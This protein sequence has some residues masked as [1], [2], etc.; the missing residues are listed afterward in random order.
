M[1][2]AHSVPDVLAVTKELSQVRGEIERADAEFR[3]LKDQIDMSEI[4]VNLASEAASRVQWAAGSS[5]KS[6]SHDLLQGLANFADFLIWLVVNVPLLL[7]WVAIIFLLVAGCW[8]VL[9]KAAR[10]MRAI[11]PKKAPTTTPAP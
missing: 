8:Y 11:F 2:K 4:D 3:H 7:L 5:V 6:A 10:M 9:K 1:K